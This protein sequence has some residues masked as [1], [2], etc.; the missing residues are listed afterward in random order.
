MGERQALRFLENNI[1]GAYNHNG[2]AIAVGT[3]FECRPMLISDEDA[4]FVAYQKELWCHIYVNI[5]PIIPFKWTGSQG[6]R[7]VPKQIQESIKYI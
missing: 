3:L 4:C 1:A 5:R 7:V 2:M 6:W